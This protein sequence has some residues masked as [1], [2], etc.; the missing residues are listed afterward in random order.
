MWIDTQQEPVRVGNVVFL[1]ESIRDGVTRNYAQS[2]PGRTNRSG[3]ARLAGWLGETNNVTRYARGLV[4]VVR[5]ADDG[6]RALVRRLRGRRAAQ[7]LVA[8][9]YPQLVEQ[10][11]E[12]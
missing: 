12:A 4:E 8:R 5:V 10:F 9:G 2:M 6:D 7:A 11:L 1:I 3:E